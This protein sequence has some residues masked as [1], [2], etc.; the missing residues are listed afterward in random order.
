MGDKAHRRFEWIGTEKEVLDKLAGGSELADTARG[1]VEYA[2]AGE[3]PIILGVHGGVGGYDQG[4]V[5]CKPFIEEGFSVV[6]PSRPGYLRTL[7][8]EERRNRDRPRG[9][10]Q[11]R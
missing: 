4:L 3:G 6:C 8:A 9:G 11:D 5:P 7:Q 2:T 1:V 10:R